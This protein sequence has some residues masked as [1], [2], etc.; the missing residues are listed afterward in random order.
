MGQLVT[1]G[2][3]SRGALGVNLHPEFRIEDALA[4]GLDRPRGAWVEGVNPRSPAAQGGV[5]EGDVV[6]RFN[7]VE[8]NDLNHLINMVSMAPIGRPAEVVV[9]RDRKQ[10]SMKVTV[11]D[12]DPLAQASPPVSRSTSDRLL[13][14]PDRPSPAT[15]FALGLELATLDEAGAQRLGLP[16]TMRGAVVIK[17]VPDSPLAKHF[18]PLD[19]IQT[20]D[21]R[22][23]RAPTTSSR[24]STGAPRG[25][26][27][28]WWSTASTGVRSSA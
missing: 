20:V 19:V 1:H 17:V 8:V 21:G 23:I 11:G 28:N 13:R 7:G 3:V 27:W 18:R 6:M 2:R 24:R 14:R 22:P 9:W 25:N 10:V 12:K 5:R 26:R 4:L 16:R 15:S